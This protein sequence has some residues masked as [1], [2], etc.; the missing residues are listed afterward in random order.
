MGARLPRLTAR[1]LIAALRRDGWVRVTQ[2]GSHYHMAHPDR[3][4]KVTIPVHTG[5]IIR[6]KL[7]Q[8]ILRQAGITPDRLKELL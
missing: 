3:P 7:L 8:M 6:P 2:V 1:E 4:G 5:T